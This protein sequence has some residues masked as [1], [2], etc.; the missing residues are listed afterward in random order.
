MCSRANVRVRL[1]AFEGP[2]HP[3]K[4]NVLRLNDITLR[5]PVADAVAELEAVKAAEAAPV[6]A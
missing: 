2:G 5:T 4:E 3:Y 1:P 6:S